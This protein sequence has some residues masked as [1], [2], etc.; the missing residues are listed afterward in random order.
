MEQN[1]RVV[2]PVSVRLNIP[3]LTRAAA[4][5]R[6][7]SGKDSMLNSLSAQIS[8]YSEYIQNRKNW[9]YRGVYADEAAT[10]TK[11]SRAEFQRLLSDC[12]AGKIDLVITKSISRFARNTVTLLNTVRE[13]KSL[14]VDI[15]FEEQNIHSISNDGEV[16]LAILAAYAQ[17][18][19]LSVSENCKWRIR[20]QFE[21]G[22][23]PLFQQRL[24]GYRRADNGGYTIAED[25][26]ETVRYIFGRYS[27][28]AGFMT[29]SNELNGSGVTA[30]QGG[31][32]NT[33]GVRY[34]LS[35]EKYIGDLRL[36][37][38]Y[39]TDHLTKSKK[40]N[41]G[42]KSQYYVDNN[43][44]PIISRAVFEGVQTEIS[45]RAHKFKA[46]AEPQKNYPLT[47]KIVCGNCGKHYK[48]RTIHGKI[49]WQCPTYTDKGKSAC[50]AKQIPDN[51]LSELTAGLGG[52][53]NI[54]QITIP[55][56]NRLTFILQNGETVTRDWQNRSRRD[57]WTPEMKQTAR[58]R[59]LAILKDRGD[60]V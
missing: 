51:V 10:G 5:A 32:W 6:V 7:S 16:M 15:Y 11:D 47:S 40:I 58:E 38:F 24:F 18:E 53:D 17:A 25:E 46:G 45:R 22:E 29:I 50:P 60:A 52:I 57:S 59:Q 41:R 37:K 30:P 2:T 20:K 36:Q 23:M 55:A 3:K 39:V 12:R 54:F 49:S 8:Y 31:L 21:N 43:H 9:Q 56:A 34:I 14:G 26:A 35:N 1:V 48:R 19:S 13:L 27:D 33:N 4:Y 42:S 44:T 28:G